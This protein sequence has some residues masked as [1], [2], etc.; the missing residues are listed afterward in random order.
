FRHAFSDPTFERS[1]LGVAKS[2]VIL[3]VTITGNR[4][5]R[6]H[7]ACANRGSYGRPLLFRIL[8]GEERERGNL[9]GAMAARTM[10]VE[11]WGNIL[12]IRDLGRANHALKS[13]RG[14]QRLGQ[15]K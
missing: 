12:G 10:A 14:I 9:S 11:D 3:E 4:L 15:D 8:V 2:R 5:P 1:D 7:Q 13:L 6:R